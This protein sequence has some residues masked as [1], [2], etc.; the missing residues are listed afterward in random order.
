[1]FEHESV[2]AQRERL[3]NTYH[4]PEVPVSHTTNHY[5]NAL[6]STKA[7]TGGL[8]LFSVCLA[9]ALGAGLGG[10]QI[11]YARAQS[12]VQQARAEA[13]AQAA[14]VAAVKACMDAIQ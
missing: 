12:D 10:M 6:T 13:A 11:G 5:Y 14:R 1:M 3:N 2:E 8:L 4:H 7:G 9:L